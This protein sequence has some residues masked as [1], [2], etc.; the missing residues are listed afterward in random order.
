Q[1]QFLFKLVQ[2]IAVHAPLEPEELSHARKEAARLR[3]ALPDLFEDAAEYHFDLSHKL[4]LT[5]EVCNQHTDAN[6]VTS[7]CRLRLGISHA[8]PQAAITKV[9]DDSL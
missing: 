6:G 4:G 8:K 9:Q 3:E 7:R 2:E 5:T 1:V